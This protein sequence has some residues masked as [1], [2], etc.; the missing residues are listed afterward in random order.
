VRANPS[1]QRTTTPPLSFH[2]GSQ[3]FLQESFVPTTTETW[4]QFFGALGIASFAPAEGSLLYNQFEQAAR[5]AF[6]RFSTGGVV[7]SEIETLMCLG[8]FV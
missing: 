4:E 6:E 8:Q 7:V 2:F 1:L 3:T 5:Q